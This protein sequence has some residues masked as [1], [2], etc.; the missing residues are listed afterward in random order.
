MKK[1]TSS[2]KT[3]KSLAS[4]AVKKNRKD[5]KKK[6]MRSK[7]LQAKKNIRNAMFKQ[8]EQYNHLVHVANKAKEQGNWNVESEDGLV[9]VSP[10]VDENNVEQIGEEGV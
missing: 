3:R 9:E 7:M 10:H 6:A 4:K 8:I 5:S 1:N 2:K